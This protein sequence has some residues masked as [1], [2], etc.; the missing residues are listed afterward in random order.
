MSGY[1]LEDAFREA[2]ALDDSAR[3]ALLDRL[4]C[5][6][7]SLAH[8]L[9][10]LL[11]AD[12]RADA[13]GLFEHPA[14]ADLAWVGVVVD[15]AWPDDAGPDDA[16]YDV[17]VAGDSATH[18]A[19]DLEAGRGAAGP[20]EQERPPSSGEGGSGGMGKDQQIG[21]YRIVSLIGRGGMGQVFLAERPDVGKRVA[22]KLLQSELASQD[23]VRRFLRERRVLAGLEHQNIV[24]LLDAGVTAEGM[25][26]FAMEFVDGVS[27]TEYCQRHALTLAARVRLFQ[28]VCTAV[29][30]AHQHLVVHRDLKPSN[31]LVDRDGCVKLLDFGI[32]KLLDSED[33]QLTHTGVSPMTPESAAP[34][35]VRRQTVTPATDVYALGL[36]LFELLA[37]ERAYSLRGLTPSR[38][39]QTVCERVPARPSSLAASQERRRIAVDLDAICLKALEKDPRQRYPT[40]GHLAADVARYLAGR[41]V[42]AR[43]PTTLYRVGKFV[44]RHRLR[45]SIAACAVA[46]AL[47]ALAG[48]L[49]Q[50]RRAEIARAESE[51]VSRFLMGLFELTD[52]AH[53]R[54]GGPTVRELIERGE[55][56]A[57]RLADQPLV[58]ARM[59]DVIGRVYHRLGDYE[60]AMVL[61][62]QALAIRRGRLGEDH[63]DVAT[64]LANLALLL[65]DAEDYDEAD[66]LHQDALARRQRL[67]GH[68]AIDTAKSLEAYAIFVL[69]VRD[70]GKR[71]EAM[72][73]EALQRPEVSP[74]VSQEISQEPGTQ[75]RG[76]ER[77]LTRA[78]LQRG[79][80]AVHSGRREYQAA[81]DLLQQ[82]VAAQRVFLGPSHP[83]T[84]QTLSLLGRSLTGAGDLAAA[85]RRVQE[86][87]ALQRQINGERHPSVMLTLANLGSLARRRGDLTR[88]EP[89]YREAVRLG[90]E[91]LGAD[92][93]TVARIS[94]GLAA[95]LAQSGRTPEAEALYRRILTTFDAKS[96]VGPHEVQ[97]VHRRLATLYQDTGQS[98]LARRHTQLAH[99]TIQ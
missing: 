66:A 71:A 89:L 54:P 57:D 10:E 75:P 88:A 77:A 72:L 40:A 24:P 50:A 25:P 17:G 80:A 26:Y 12:A 5:D 38:I 29:E 6:N 44:R 56:H 86:V 62:R 53:G 20:R 14:A 9:R 83:D 2:V 98:S 76:E 69:R 28:T 21:G 96:D 11:E 48:V 84:I 93:A 13:R 67:L 4:A 81:A 23:D 68:G 51:A 94:V 79:L 64:S 60:R 41:P 1:R 7:A 18:A 30:H 99:A 32:A 35:Q 8:E 46:L 22:V 73:R 78:V 91:I 37:G 95:V 65:Q 59:F 70:D 39:E 47:G 55:R 92:H 19:A 16:A 15:D 49:W 82:T 58:Q 90:E 43:T 85:E 45:L 27:I 3:M 31:I 52:P 34:E 36:L 61:L 97:D 87:L 74:E 33:E 42:K 63:A